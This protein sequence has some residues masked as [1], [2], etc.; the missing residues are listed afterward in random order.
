MIPPR[1]I[2]V[3]FTFAEFS[4]PDSQSKDFNY[5][6]LNYAPDAPDG[7]TKQRRAPVNLTCARHKFCRLPVLLFVL[8]S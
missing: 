6:A 5:H 3:S 8:Y 1:W 4:T 2:N 7:C